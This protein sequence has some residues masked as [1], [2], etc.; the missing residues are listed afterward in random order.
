MEED[1]YAFLAANAGV[2]AI[3]GDRITWGRRPQGSALPAIVLHNISSPQEYGMRGRVTRVGHLVQVDCWAADFDT[4][5]LAS[6]AVTAAMDLL[7]ASPLQ[8]FIESARDDNEDAAGPDASGAETF[9]R[10]SL[11]VRVWHLPT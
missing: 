8:A 11:D 7:T 4:A 2:A 3:V 1:L 9:F 6:R 5:K 10:T